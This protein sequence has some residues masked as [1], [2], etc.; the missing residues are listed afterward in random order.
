MKV[1]VQ[2]K[3]TLYEAEQFWVDD[4]PWPDGVG[5]NEDESLYII[6]N[7]SLR[8]TINDGDWIVHLPGKTDIMPDKSLRKFYDIVEE[9]K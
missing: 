5:Q 6:I 9:I 1:L 8:Y 7:P 3:P 4:F 2:K